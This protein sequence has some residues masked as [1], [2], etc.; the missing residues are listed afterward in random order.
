MFPSIPKSL[1]LYWRWF[2]YTTL[3]VVFVWYRIVKKINPVLPMLFFM[4]AAM[5]SISTRIRRLV[6]EH[7][8]SLFSFRKTVLP[9]RSRSS[10]PPHSRPT[11][12]PCLCLWLN[13]SILNKYSIYCCSGLFFIYFCSRGFQWSF[14]L[15][16]D[17]HC[18]WVIH[19]V[20][21]TILTLNL[22]K[23]HEII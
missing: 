19:T 15:R 6:L 18:I 16:K 7:Q 9:I 23:N 1:T 5:R 14:T 3:D 12:Y 13:L 11:H 22:S 8:E 10:L 4:V 17:P 20:S 21:H 2:V